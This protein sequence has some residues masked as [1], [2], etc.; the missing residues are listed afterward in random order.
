MFENLKKKT[1]INSIG[2]KKLEI[3]I[4]LVTSVFYFVFYNL[5]SPNLQIILKFF[6]YI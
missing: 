1:K 2:K 6:L 4:F 5:T 3:N